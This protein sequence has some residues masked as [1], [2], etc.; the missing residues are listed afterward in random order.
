MAISA[1]RPSALRSRRRTGPRPIAPGH[2]VQPLRISLLVG[3]LGVLTVL[4]PLTGAA[5]TYVSAQQGS[6]MYVPV[7]VA[8]TPATVTHPL[9]PQQV[10]P[11]IADGFQ[12]PLAEPGTTD[13]FGI[14][15]S[16]GLSGGIAFLDTPVDVPLALL[17]AGGPLLVGLTV[18]VLAGLMM[19]LVRTTA[20]REPFAPGN[21]ARLTGAA[22]TLLVAAAAGTLLPYWGAQ[23]LL[24]LP[25]VT[26]GMWVPD[27]QPV[28]WPLPA[29]ALL[30]V[31]AAA[32]HTGSALRRQ[33]EG[34]V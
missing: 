8:G 14:Y 29:A 31:L 30:L 23:R 22:L 3:A 13:A 34:L 28:L 32:V 20:A 15:A 2:L 19:G 16:G 7:R 17:A 21:A 11:S 18:A 9:V 4:A 1:F 27:A 6:S 26:S 12:A 5:L 33:T 25:P 10:M 24:D